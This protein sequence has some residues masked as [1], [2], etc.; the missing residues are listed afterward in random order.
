MK[1]LEGKFVSSKI[2]EEIKN[3]IKNIKIKPTLAI[4]LVGDNEASLVYVKAKIKACENVGVKPILIKY[5]KNISEDEI[6]NKVKELN[7][8]KNINGIIIQSPLPSNISF[9]NIINHIHPLK[10]IDGLNSESVYANYMNKKGFLPCTVKGIIKLLNFYEIDVCDKNVTIIGRSNLVGKPLNIALNN[11][12]ATVTMCHSK[13]KDISLFTKTA[14]I[15][16]SATG[17]CNLITKD[18]VK[19]NSTIIDVGI[20]RVNNK[21]IGDVDFENVK[22]HVKYITK[23]P[24]GVGPMTVSMVI[25]NTVDA[26]K[27]QNK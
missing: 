16:I 19:D 18:M 24:G 25:S 8:D 10:D 15:V 14:D 9:D 11:L 4:I 23:V 26:Y 5:D 13:T 7:N 20:T 6:I 27:M 3:E 12:G 1:I 2:L 17:K 22:D 21:L